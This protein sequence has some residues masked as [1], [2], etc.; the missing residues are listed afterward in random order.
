MC[1]LNGHF[2][3]E[4]IQMSNTHMKRF[5]APLSIR[6]IQIK[7]TM[8]YHLTPK[9]RGMAKKTANSKC[10]CGCRETEPSYIVNENIKGGSPFGKQFGSSSKS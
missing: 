8:K 6:G 2:S 5:S 4:E 1:N 10:R 3:E 7:T 9:R